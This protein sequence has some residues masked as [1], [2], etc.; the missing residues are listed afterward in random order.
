MDKYKVKIS[1]QAYR[2][3]ERIYQYIAETL[4]EKQ[5]ALNI[6]DK[7][8][9]AMLSLDEMPYRGAE[10]KIGIYANKGYRQIIVKNYTIIYRINEPSKT[11]IIVT[12]KYSMRKF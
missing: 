9:T 8:Q 7:L 2:E 10:R 5:T 6:I 1:P 4:T 12:V 11:I 3:L